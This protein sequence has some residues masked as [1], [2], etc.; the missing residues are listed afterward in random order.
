MNKYLVFKVSNCPLY[1]VDRAK[2]KKFWWS[3]LLRYAILFTS[4]EEAQKKADS[5][6]YG[7][8]KVIT[9]Y[10]AKLIR[11]NADLRHENEIDNY[12]SMNNQDPGDSEYWNNKD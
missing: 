12:D 9:E 10:E 6:K 5:L 8:F 11:Q 3:Y 7:V 1:L 4:R 2:T